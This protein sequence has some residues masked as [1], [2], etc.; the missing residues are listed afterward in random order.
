MY[1]QPRTRARDHQKSLLI[2]S[3]LH[4]SSLL[5]S[6]H[7]TALELALIELDRAHNQ[8]PRSLTN[9]EHRRLAKRTA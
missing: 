6:D 8:V 3:L 4:R 5:T 1:K 9:H 7:Q 2:E